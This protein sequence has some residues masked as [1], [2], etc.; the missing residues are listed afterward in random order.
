MGRG[1]SRAPTRAAEAALDQGL[2]PRLRQTNLDLLP[3]LHELLRTGS[4]S[5][6]ARSFGMTQPA[7]SRALR[8]LR[9]AFGDDLLV[10]IGR[11]VVP[12]AKAE[13]LAEPLHRVLG[14]IDSLIRPATRFDPAREG[15]HV[16]I[17]TADYV[18]LLLAP[19]LTRICAGEAPGVVFEFVDAP[20]RIAEDLARCDF[21]LTPRAF[22]MTLGK[23]VGT[24]P[25]WQDDIV[26]LAPKR[27]RTI[28]NRIS[29]EQFRRSRQAG[30]QMN[31]R[32]PASIRALLQPTAILET[33]RACTV[34]NFMVLGAI[35][36]QADC[37]ALVPRKLA[38]QVIRGRAL[39]I[40]ELGFAQKQ[41]AIDAYWSPA[42]TG[43]RGHAWAR[44]LLARAA[45]LLD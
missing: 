26:C 18:S 34:P 36:E 23:R 42:V 6:T 22:G 2:A 17:A 45:K 15:L 41:F 40:V 31:P 33:Q 12:T 35:V 30:F 5:R 16:T 3:V 9:A 8:Q 1:V 21:L 24:L 29:A 25:L 7:V 4:V 19:I 13:A 10:S 20:L 11:G 37:V 32:V 28:G 43:K 44:D 27:S 14:E 39:K 38:A